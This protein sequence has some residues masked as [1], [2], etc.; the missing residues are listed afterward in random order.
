MPTA[1][2]RRSSPKDR[3]VA[4]LLVTGVVWAVTMGELAR[5][6]VLARRE[7]AD[8][9]TLVDAAGL[10]ESHASARYAIRLGT[11]DIGELSSTVSGVQR[12]D[13]LG[14]VLSGRVGQPFRIGL[15]GFV[16]AD[17][18]RRPERFVL[19]VAL[20]GESHRLEGGLSPGGPEGV[21]LEARYV[22]PG[23][24][25]ARVQ[26]W[27]LPDAPRLAPG[28]LPLPELA[29]AAGDRSRPARAGRM[30]DPRTGEPA[31]WR[32]ESEAG[33]QLVV[34]GTRRDVVRHRL[35]FADLEATAWVEPSGFP[36]RVELPLGIAVE[37]VQ[38]ER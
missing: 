12:D 28:P 23:D 25:R 26:S 33:E 37:L 30:I 16:L 9:R 13:Q 10:R 2:N 17:W 1:E 21:L 27:M 22:P 19:E 35:R 24:G 11:L 3:A 29:S 14:Y 31:D 32:I 36:V 34:A 5:R 6:E 4:L 8:V 15:R 18:E 20:A 7:A 38:E